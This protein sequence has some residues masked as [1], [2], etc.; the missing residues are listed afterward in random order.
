MKSISVLLKS[1]ILLLV[2]QI[3]IQFATFMRIDNSMMKLSENKTTQGASPL[4]S[5]PDLPKT[6][7]VFDSIFHDF[8]V[9]WDSKKVYT[10]FR[11]T[12]TG[13]EPLM[14]LS[15]EGSCGCTV[16]SWPKEPIAPG[17][18]NI[19][20]ISFDPGGKSGEQSKIVTITSNSEPSTSILTIK[21]T[22]VKSG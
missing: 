12:N 20:E 3:I 5:M 9:I 1:I 8:G 21:A 14:I 16:P 6:S 15:A 22:I 7:I 10:K 17:E 4:K 2:I 18:S 19:I 11:F 13:K